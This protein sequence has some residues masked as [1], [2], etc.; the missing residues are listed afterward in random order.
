MTF[1]S[2]RLRPLIRQTI[3]MICGL[4][5][6]LSMATLPGFTQVSPAG[7]E[8]TLQTQVL[9]VGTEADYI[10]FEYRDPVSGAD[11]I[12]GFDIDIA[13]YIAQQLGLELQVQDI[14][15]EQLLPAVA[16][17][18]LDFAIAAI[19]P[20]I[21]R[22]Q[23]LD[24]SDPYYESRHALISRRSAPVRTLSDI[25]GK[26]VTVQ[27]GSVQE[28]LLLQ[29]VGL[30]IEVTSISTLNEMVSTIREGLADVAMVEEL[31]AEA[32]L[33]NNPTLEMDVLGELEPSP[34]AIAF[35]KDSPYIEDFNA[36]IADMRNSGE[37]D[38]IARR[39]FTA[40]P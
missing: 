33:E 1:H 7:D 37:L 32:Y 5:L 22:A 39:W 27:S 8:D 13:N 23:A 36:V 3:L 10:P 4:S 18:E 9:Q 15:F 24:F 34:V 31:V 2:P 16:S 25:V 20:T 11:E 19:T 35:P 28:S 21:E 6:V 26:K 40:D 38:V 29:R 17:G 12:I 30:N 14:P